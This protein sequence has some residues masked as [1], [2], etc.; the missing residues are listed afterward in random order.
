MQVNGTKTL[1]ENLSDNVGLN[2]SYKAYK[3]WRNSHKDELP[4]P[5]LDYT[6]EQLFWM[7]SIHFLCS[8]N[9]RTNR[10]STILLGD[11]A[12]PG[13]RARGSVSNSYEFAKAFNCPLGSP[14]NPE[15]K[16]YLW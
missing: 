11:H 7:T 16:C 1:N 3:K 4:L 5:G 13:I 12:L 8:K 6:P 10:I 15:Q 2:V 14:M 9:S